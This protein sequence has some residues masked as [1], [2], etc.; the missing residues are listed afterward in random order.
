MHAPDLTRWFDIPSDLKHAVV[1]PTPLGSLFSALAFVAVGGLLL[2][3]IR[4][5]L[6]N[7]KKRS[8]VDRAL[9]MFHA[10]ER[11][12]L[13]YVGYIVGT[14]WR[15]PLC[16]A[17]VSVLFFGTIATSGALLRWPFCLWA[18]IVGLFGVLVVFRQ[19]SHDEE[20]EE[21]HIQAIKREVIRGTR[22]FE[23][24]IACASVL[25]YAPVVFA[26]LQN[27]GLGFDVDPKAGP[28]AFEGF[29]LIEMLKIA[30]LVQYYDVYA[31]I[32]NFQKLGTVANPSFE[33]KFAVIAFRATSDLIILAAIKRFFDIAR[34]AAAG[35]DLRPAEEKLESADRADRA[36]GVREIGMSALE[37]R[38][39]ARERL[40]RILKGNEF[41]AYPDVKFETAMALCKLAK[42][43]QGN[44]EDE[45]RRLLYLAIDKGYEPLK[46][47][48]WTQDL[49]EPNYGYVRLRLGDA[50]L[51]IGERE[52]AK[53][54]KLQARNSYGAARE[55]F[56]RRQM[57]AAL[58]QAQEG[59]AKASTLLSGSA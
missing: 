45:S 38:P 42:H 59:W 58:Q 40:E 35:L 49:N 47:N 41:S 36:T 5:L 6:R 16:R 24:I 8:R 20:D 2:T 33:A 19:W 44:D 31:D 46:N 50:L 39:F 11:V 4:Y 15:S 55:I 21:Y 56:S 25:I 9:Q 54:R 12:A 22:N 48:V 7:T 34:R 57:T 43:V 37:G 14:T 26:Q 28:F 1:S 27:A 17:V 10:A 13:K 32:L 51:A 53:A 29:T 52:A 23:L 3:A 30:P 18:A